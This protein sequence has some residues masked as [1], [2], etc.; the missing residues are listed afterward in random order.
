MRRLLF[1]LAVCAG[2]AMTIPAFAADASVSIKN[3]AY[4]PPTVTIRQGERVTW[5]N[6]DTVGHSVTSDTGTFDSTKSGKTCSPSDSTGCI[7][8]GDRFFITFNAPGTFAYH[9]TVHSNMHGKVV[10]EPKAS[11]TPKVTAAPKTATPTVRPTTAP[12]V[13][14]VAPTSS[15]PPTPSPTATPVA[16]LGTAISPIGSPFSSPIAFGTT[17]KSNRGPLIGIAIAAV[18]LAAGGGLLYFFRVRG[19]RP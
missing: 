13:R 19:M 15:P 8:P 3:I 2:V 17:T 4:N 7:Q 5:T 9:C 6:N 1:V 12:A 16:T 14:T 10:V 11:P 18:A